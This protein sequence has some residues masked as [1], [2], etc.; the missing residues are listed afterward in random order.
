MNTLNDLPR[1]DNNKFD[2]NQ[3][4]RKLVEELL[5]EVMSIQADEFC[6]MFGTSR[7]GYRARGLIT[8]MGEITLL[9]PKI[10]AGTYFPDDIIEKWSRT[11]TALASAIC[12]MW[13]NGISNRK[14]EKIVSKLGVEK[15]S[16]SKVSRLCKTLDS[17]IEAL[18]KGDLSENEWPYLWLDATYMHCRCN[19]VVKSTALV[20]AVAVN[21]EARRQ[22]I[23]ISYFDTENYLDWRDFLLSIKN[24]GLNGVKL[25]VSDEHAGLVRAINEIMIGAS[26]QRCIA[27][28]EKNLSNRIRKKELSGAAIGALKVAFEEE[29]P[30]L[31][32][33]GYNK[34]ISLLE[35]YDEKGAVLLDKAKPYALAYLSFPKEHAKWIR[36]NNLVERINCEMKRRSNVIQVFPNTE[37][38]IRL[39]GAISCDYNDKWISEKWFINKEKLQK[40]Q[41][42]R[43]NNIIK[44]EDIKQIERSVETKFEDLRKAA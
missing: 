41:P 27:H 32:E 2:I 23:G 3:I 6:E 28:L 37:S 25:V 10:R 24:R 31:V 20:L 14:V 30:Q 21:N 18:R 34:A 42:I 4:A 33:A 26:H 15:M 29:N 36:T 44:D 17:E 7:N 8:S 43:Q 35:K 13:I 9:V 22:I 12:D 11:D 38:M 5:N 19:G 1:L 16:K 40:L 39:A